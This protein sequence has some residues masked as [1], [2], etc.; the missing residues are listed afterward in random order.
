M[1]LECPRLISRCIHTIER[2]VPIVP[3]VLLDV[4]NALPVHEA[5]P[6]D[7]VYKGY[8]PAS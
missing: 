5:C 7:H 8:H 1:G 4:G 6:V 3:Q 2:K